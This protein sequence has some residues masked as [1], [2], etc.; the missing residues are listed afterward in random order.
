MQWNEST[1]KIMNN[2]CNVI[3]KMLLYSSRDCED[4]SLGSH[5]TSK[6][7]TETLARL[8][9]S[10]SDSSPEIFKRIRKKLPFHP[11]LGSETRLHVGC[12]RAGP[13]TMRDV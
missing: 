5:P 1:K 7:H 10:I 2:P 6:L 8:D 12:S 9:A 4:A 3:V 13:H 11:C